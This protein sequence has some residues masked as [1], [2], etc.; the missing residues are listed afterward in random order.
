MG[1]RKPEKKSTAEVTRQ[2]LSAR[3]FLRD[4]L[5]E[6]LI[7][8]SALA[9]K[10]AA[11][12]GTHEDAVY[13]SLR[14]Y[15]SGS[16][17]RSVV[18]AVSGVIRESRMSMKDRIA[19]VSVKKDWTTLSKLADIARV[20]R[21]GSIFQIVIGTGAITIILEDRY[22]EKVLGIIGRES[23]IKSRR[24]LV[25]LA[26]VSPPSI[27]DVPGVVAHVTSALAHNGVNVVEM[28]SCHQ[29]I[30][31]VLEEECLMRAYDVLRG[32]L[33]DHAPPK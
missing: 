24:N 30:I 11:E 26:M 32:L 15:A 33:K 19:T 8:Y 23:L 13:I 21:E 14:R 16:K 31:V 6:G 9:R 10:I 1:T 22:L 5:M 25:E 17:E 7:N 27:E 18:D 4:M 12:T 28:A 20:I 2:Y 29:D 3:P